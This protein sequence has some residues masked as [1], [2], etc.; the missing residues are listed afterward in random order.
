MWWCNSIWCK[1]FRPIEM[2]VGK[3]GDAL[4]SFCSECRERKRE[5]YATD[6]V[7]RERAKANARRYYHEHKEEIAIVSKI[8]RDNNLDQVFAKRLWVN[9][10]KRMDWYNQT[11][12]DQNYVCKICELPDPRGGRLAVDHDHNCCPGQKSCGDCVRGLICTT[13]NTGMGNF[14]DDIDLL[15]R[16]IQYLEAYEA[17]LKGVL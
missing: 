9:H 1:D 8:W 2:F 5:E 3:K 12:M 6:P 17:T 16:A 7:A 14:H 15:Y 13:C 11:L 10:R 4:Y